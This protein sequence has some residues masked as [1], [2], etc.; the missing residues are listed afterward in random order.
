MKNIF[1]PESVAVIG[2]SNI[3]RKW[4]NKIIAN[5]ITGGY[6]GAVY[7]INPKETTV[8][9]LKSYSSV[10][11]VPGEIDLAIIVIPAVHVIAAVDECGRKGVKGLIVISAGFAEAENKVLEEELQN[12]VDHYDMMMIGPNCLGIANNSIN[13]NASILQEMPKKGNIS[14]IAQSGTMALTIVEWAK[15]K[16]IGLCKVISTGNKTDLDDVDYLEY[17]N[18][19]PDTKVIAIYA[20]SIKRGRRFIEVAKRI[21]KPIIILKVGRSKK[22]AAACFSHTAS[23]AGD[24]K[25]F[26]AAFHQAGIIR[27]DTLEE[28]FDAAHVFSCQPLPKGNRVG[29][30]SNGGG[31][32]IIAMDE[33]E[34]YGID[35]PNL[36]AEMVD[37]IKAVMPGFASANNPVDSAARSDNNIYKTILDTFNCDSFDAIISIFIQDSTADPMPSA[38][39]II[40]VI[41]DK[42]IIACAMAGEQKKKWIQVL[43]DAGIPVYPS[44]DRAVKALNYLIQHKKF[45]D[46]VKI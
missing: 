46:E 16:G 18:S 45:L 35:V 40:S 21:K 9:G 26:S 17:L 37:K 7:P 38:T 24:D 2:A 43:E 30:C 28:L 27:V 10:L 22:G 14:F 19:D 36:T 8:Q 11:D 12:K 4:S 29:V 25:I 23:L 6:T 44:P 13:L 41:T 39:D 15:E 33:C 34:K 5:I 42:P 32:G 3:K 1:E 31:S 20:E